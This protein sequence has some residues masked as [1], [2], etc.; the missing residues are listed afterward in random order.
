MKNAG[1]LRESVAKATEALGSS[2]SRGHSAVER[3]RPW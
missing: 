2:R 3:S 1:K